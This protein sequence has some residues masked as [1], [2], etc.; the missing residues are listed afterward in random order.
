M[1]WWLAAGV[2]A[3]FLV[4]CGGGEK[5]VTTTEPAGSEPAQSDDASPGNLVPVTALTP[6]A[7]KRCLTEGEAII[8]SVESLAP[9]GSPINATGV[10]ALG[11]D[12]GRI[13]IALTLKRFITDRLANEL[14]GEGKYEIRK[15]RDGRA[16]I[17]LDSKASSKDEALAAECVEG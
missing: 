3:I 7:V 11:P 17:V 16:I 12:G 1:R 6:P 14:A 2:V 13:G 5:T 10:F 15:T 9:A 4:G 8:M